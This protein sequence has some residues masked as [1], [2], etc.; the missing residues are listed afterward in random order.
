MKDIYKRYILFI[1]G[2]LLSRTLLVYFVR[3]VNKKYLPYLGYLSLIPA[4]GFAIIYSFGLRKTGRETYGSPIWWNSLRPL[5][6]ALYF[7]FSYMA[8][9][10]N[11]NSYIP[12][13]FDVL[14]GGL[15]FFGYH[16]FLAK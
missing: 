6:S 15:S 4:L 13:L 11:R 5:H 9:Q 1:F 3:K 10:G 8:I 16:I 7:T 2:C 12:L 14:I